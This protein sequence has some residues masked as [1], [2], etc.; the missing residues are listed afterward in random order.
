MSLVVTRVLGLATVQDAGRPGHMHAG[1]PHGG[2][3]VRELLAC[4]NRNVRNPDAAAAIEV[5]GRLVVRATA[6]I[7]VATDSSARRTL[8][9][10]DE[11]VVASE[12]RRVAYLAVRGG[13]DAPLVLGS[14]S[15]HA[16]AGL[17]AP[18]AANSTIAAG[19]LP[20]HDAPPASFSDADTIR[21]IPGPDAFPVAALATLTT[22][23]F[24]ISPSSDRVGTRLD[25]PAL[26]HAVADRS[27]PMVR[28]AIEVP[29]DGRPIVLGPEHPTTGGYPV[30]AV[31]AYADLGRFFAIRLGGAVRFRT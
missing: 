13:V 21:I 18:L 19:A 30:I 12:P 15:T 24:R 9:A 3:L 2:A 26:A 7:E 17:G 16:S 10:G 5:L 4:A 6:A 11:L 20:P 27:R 29:R 1:L 14:R 28:G 31:I 22:S 25:G 8:H 23:T